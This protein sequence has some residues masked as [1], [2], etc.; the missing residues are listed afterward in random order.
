MIEEML[1]S[2][3]WPTAITTVVA[4]VPIL[5]GLYKL[6]AAHDVR[7]LRAEREAHD[8]TKKELNNARGQYLRMKAHRDSLKAENAE[9]VN[10]NEAANKKSNKPELTDEETR[11]L[12][13]LS[14]D[15]MYELRRPSYYER[16]SLTGEQMSDQRITLAMDRL[17]ELGF[18]GRGVEGAFV[19]PEGRK[20]LDDN[21]ML[22]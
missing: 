6:I 1:R 15:R 10:I 7:A 16:R 8:N 17:R 2:I 3:N 22:E 11:V 9:L 13:A 12:K 18:V 20:W 5:I 4:I 19:K 14:E 21:G